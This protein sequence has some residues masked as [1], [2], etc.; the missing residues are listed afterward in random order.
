MFQWAL[1]PK[2][3]NQILY[4]DTIL[5]TIKDWYKCTI[6]YDTNFRMVQVL[7]LSNKGQGSSL[8]NYS[9]YWRS[10]KPRDPNTMDFNRMMVEECNDLM[11]KGACVIFQ[12]T[13]TSGYRVQTAL[14]RRTTN[15]DK[16]TNQTR[17]MTSRKGMPRR[18]SLTSKLSLPN[19][20]ISCAI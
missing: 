11:N 18:S 9:R 16:N 5:T 2:L 17:E 3:A 10:E 7:T 1:N 13:R 6:Q 12:G 19:R 8:A 4:A 15:Q 20:G 14:R